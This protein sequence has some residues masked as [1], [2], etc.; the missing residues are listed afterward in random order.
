MGSRLN[1]QDDSRKG[2]RIVPTLLPQGVG[3]H[4]EAIGI[5]CLGT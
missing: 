2:G 1:L 3:N 4:E 5:T